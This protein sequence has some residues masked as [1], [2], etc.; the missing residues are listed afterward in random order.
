MYFK[1][2]Y[3]YETVNGLVESTFESVLLLAF[4]HMKESSVIG[5][6]LMYFSEHGFLRKYTQPYMLYGMAL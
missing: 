3:V 5:V 2:P 4:Q 1:N 6:I